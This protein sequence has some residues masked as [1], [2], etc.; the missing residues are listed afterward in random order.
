RSTL[1]SPEV[2]Q[3]GLFRPSQEHGAMSAQLRV[4]FAQHAAQVPPQGHG[5]GRLAGPQRPAP[6][7]SVS[8]SKGENG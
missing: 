6:Q 2:S 3:T 5:Q 8:A 1:R 4:R 7:A